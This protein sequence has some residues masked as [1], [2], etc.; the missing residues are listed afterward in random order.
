MYVQLCS[1][2]VSIFV[3]C[4]C[5]S[6][7]MSPGG[8]YVCGMCECLQLSDVFVCMMCLPLGSVSV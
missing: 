3:W 4:V 8:W 2:F 6:V 1:V 5:V 7:Y